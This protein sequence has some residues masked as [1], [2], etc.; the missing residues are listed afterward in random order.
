MCFCDQVDGL[1]GASVFVWFCYLHD[2]SLMSFDHNLINT[3][4]MI[5]LK[6]STIIQTNF[7]TACMESNSSIMN[8]MAEA[9]DVWPHPTDKEGM[10]NEQYSVLLRACEHFLSNN[11]VGEHYCWIGT[12]CA[13]EH[14]HGY[15]WLVLCLKS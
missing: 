3:D 2:L 11:T 6:Y 1:S 7:I 14:Y 4:N 12:V 5:A 15:V 9:C 8:L 13:A 10:K